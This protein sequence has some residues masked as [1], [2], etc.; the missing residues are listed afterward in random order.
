MAISANTNI[1][2]KYGFIKANELNVGDVVYDL[3]GDVTQVISVSKCNM[4]MRVG[5]QFG[6]TETFIVSDSQ[7]LIGSMPYKGGIKNKHETIEYIAASQIFDM[8]ANGWAMRIP[9]VKVIGEGSHDIDPWVFGFWLGDG[10]KRHPVVS[11]SIDDMEAVKNLIIKGGY[12]IGSVRRDKRFNKNGVSIYI[13]GTLNRQ[14]REIGVKNNK[15][16]PE[17][18]YGTSTEYRKKFLSGL[19][20]SDGTIENIRGRAIFSNTNYNIALGCARI[21]ASLGEYP[22]LYKMNGY[23]FGKQV[24]YYNVSWTPINVPSQ[25]MRK[26]DRIRERKVIERRT[27][28]KCT[29]IAD[30]S[31]C[32]GYE[33]KTK[34]GTILVTNWYI[35]IGA[36]HIPEVNQDTAN[37]MLRRV[38]SCT[39]FSR[40][41]EKIKKNI[42]AIS[43]VAYEIQELRQD[44]RTNEWNRRKI[45][46]DGVLCYGIDDAANMVGCSYNTICR[47]IKRGDGVVWGH[48]ISLKEYKRTSEVSQQT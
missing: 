31:D 21:V 38:S 2:T 43:P 17:W 15:H 13:K 33:I 9:Q 24:E 45:I 35:P 22:C 26:A 4:A 32:S 39:I 42:N 47:A 37:I 44:H 19:V 14:L 34:S 10:S 1:P 23:G 3:A 41:K 30:F 12:S 20:D 29:R 46:I 7:I 11:T 28:G 36:G 6:Q 40:D 8:S 18:I 48:S 25:L 16:I 27:Y 5:F